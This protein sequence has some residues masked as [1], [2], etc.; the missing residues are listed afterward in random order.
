MHLL[1]AR[2]AHGRCLPVGGRSKPIE[3][4]KRMAVQY[5]VGDPHDS[6]ETQQSFLI[7]F[8][9][10]HQIGVIAEIP[11]KPVKFPESPWGAIKPTGERMTLVLFWFEN[12]EPDDKKWPL[13]MPAVKCPVDADQEN[14]FQH[15]FTASVF[16]MK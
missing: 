8:I 4:W 10:A 1:A 15:A 2:L 7:D 3:I 14:A 6:P 12:N 13:R 16:M 9:S 5:R 11:Q